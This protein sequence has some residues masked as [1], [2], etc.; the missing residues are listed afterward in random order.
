LF[1][2]PSQVHI[3]SEI[4]HGVVTGVVEDHIEYRDAGARVATR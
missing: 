1:G 2:P 4:A 3:T